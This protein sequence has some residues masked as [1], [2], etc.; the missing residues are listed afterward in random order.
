LG[1]KERTRGEFGIWKEIITLSKGDNT[2]K[3]GKFF[4]ITNEFLNHSRT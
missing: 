4:D 3:M 1:E 2:Q